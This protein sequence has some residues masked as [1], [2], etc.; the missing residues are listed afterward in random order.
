MEEMKNAARPLELAIV[1]PTFNEL[2]NV[3]PVLNNLA[4]ALTGIR[5]EVIFVD[6]DHLVSYSRQCVCQII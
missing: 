5:Y 4:N 1:I 6:E 3:R 2:D